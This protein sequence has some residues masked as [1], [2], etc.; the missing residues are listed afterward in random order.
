MRPNLV[1]EYTLNETAIVELY[2]KKSENI[3]FSQYE[4]VDGA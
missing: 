1:P 2:C 3:A 4:A